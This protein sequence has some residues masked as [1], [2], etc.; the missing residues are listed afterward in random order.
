MFRSFWLLINSM[1]NITDLKARIKSITETRKITKAMELISIS[2]LRRAQD[3]YDRNMAYFN[4][5]RITIK[6]IAVHSKEI[7]HKYLT[8]RS[9]DRAAYVVIA[10][11]KGLAGGYNHNVLNLAWSHMKDRSEKVIFTIGHTATEFFNRINVPADMEFLHV[12]QNPCLSDARN[13]TYDI[14]SLFDNNY[15]DEAFVVYSDFIS[16]TSISPQILKL[17]PVVENEM[18]DIELTSDYTTPVLYDPSPIEVL[19]LLIP[20]YV[21]G[22][23]YN[24]LIHSNAS[25]HKARMIAM[26]NATRNAD[27]ML[28]RLALE[29]NRARQEAITSELLEIISAENA[30]KEVVSNA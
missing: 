24:C 21:V 18:L 10:S 28:G 6:D 9:G 7:Y 27:E 5:L 20:Q 22:M 12:S 30:L 29:Y 2:K 14:L 25:E 11:D 4:K 15:I 19:D 3:K 13:I 23:M 17:L 8:K 26:D 16:S 1:Q